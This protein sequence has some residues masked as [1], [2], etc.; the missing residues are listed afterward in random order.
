LKNGTLFHKI[1]EDDASKQFFFL[2]SVSSEGTHL[3][4]FFT[5]PICFKCQMTTEWSMLSSSA[6]SHIVIRGSALMMALN[7]SLSTSDGQPPRSSSLRLS[8][9][10]KNFLNYQ[11]MVQSLALPG[12]NVL[13][14]L[15]VVSAAL[16]PILNSN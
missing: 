8:S 14:M 13:L 1:R 4:S 9:P 12:P 11:C 15:Q 7:W 6:A 2:F 5:F 16:Q 3:S 10:L